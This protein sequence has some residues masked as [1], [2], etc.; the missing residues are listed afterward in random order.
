M[1][2]GDYSLHWRFLSS[3]GGS[4]NSPVSAFVTRNYTGTIYCIGKKTPARGVAGA[5][6]AASL[7]LLV[8]RH[9]AEEE[10]H[11]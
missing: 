1:R 8:A 7:L 2:W 6:K 9:S 10:V 11:T 5:V 3:G 4:G